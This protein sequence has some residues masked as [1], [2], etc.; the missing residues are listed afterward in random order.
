[1]ILRVPI[2]AALKKSKKN[3]DFHYHQPMPLTSRQKLSVPFTSSIDQL[4]GNDYVLP[5]YHKNL[6]Q[7]AIERLEFDIIELPEL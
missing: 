6:K 7:V 5:V 2:S 3:T 1:M 4:P